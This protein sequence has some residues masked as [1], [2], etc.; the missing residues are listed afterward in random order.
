MLDAHRHS[1]V[2]LLLENYHRQ[3]VLVGHDVAAMKQE[4]ESLQEL[5]AISLDVSLNSMIAVD[6]RL[7]M[8]NLGVATSA[9]IFGAMG[10]NTIN[11]LESSH[12]GFYC[13]LGGSAAASAMALGGVMRHLRSV[14][15]A[16]DS[17]QGKLMALNTIC[18]HVD[19]IESVLRTELE[20]GQKTA[21]GVIKRDAMARKL[22]RTRGKEIS[23]EEL[24]LIFAVFDTSGDGSID[25][26]EYGKLVSDPAG[27]LGSSSGAAART[28]LPSR[29]GGN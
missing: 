18:D 20:F 21:A 8:L 1:V 29:D 15:R 19:D 7:A 12:V 26:K 23:E 13:L 25:T 3:L 4:M 22:A 27:S 16:G 28:I 5:S 14:V 11:G 6:V 17:Q 24:D 10:M 2:E 9:C